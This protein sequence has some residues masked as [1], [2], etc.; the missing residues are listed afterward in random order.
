MYLNGDGY[1]RFNPTEDADILK[2]IAEFKAKGLYPWE[3]LLAIQ[4]YGAKS[5][6]DYWTI[7]ECLSCCCEETAKQIRK[8]IDVA[9]IAKDDYNTMTIKEAVDRARAKINKAPAKMIL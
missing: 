3:S 2:E 9:Q 1:P 4:K 5:V 8:V 7:S 6:Q